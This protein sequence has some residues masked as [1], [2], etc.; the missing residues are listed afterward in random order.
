MSKKLTC[1]VVDDEPMARE[2]MATYIAKV[3]V[4]AGQTPPNS[5]YL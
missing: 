3:T 2:I 1:I 4:P 5:N